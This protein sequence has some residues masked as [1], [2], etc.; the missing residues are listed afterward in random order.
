MNIIAIE[1]VTWK[2]WFDGLKAKSKAGVR[3]VIISLVGPKVN[4][5]FWLDFSYTNNP[6]KYKA[7]IIGLLILL[8]NLL[9]NYAIN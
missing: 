6:T 2:L 7:L 9:I 1:P 8:D 3:V 4:L 5:L